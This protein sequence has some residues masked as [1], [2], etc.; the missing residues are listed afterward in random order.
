[1]YWNEHSKSQGDRTG[2]RLTL[3]WDVLKFYY[4][5]NQSFMAR[6]I[7]INMRCIEIRKNGKYCGRY[8]GLTLTWDVLKYANFTDTVWSVTD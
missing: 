3:T 8:V 5:K 7:N 6:A 2:K 4:H 1:M